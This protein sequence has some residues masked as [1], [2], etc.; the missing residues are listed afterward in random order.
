MP[1]NSFNVLQPT[2]FEY[3][4]ANSPPSGIS[5]QPLVAACSSIS[6]RHLSLER[7]STVELLMWTDEQLAGGPS[8]DYSKTS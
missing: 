7:K 8:T 6:R 1:N 2:L 5:R 3:R 4:A